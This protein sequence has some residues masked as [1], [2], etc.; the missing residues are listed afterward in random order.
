[1]RGESFRAIA[2]LLG[3][4]NLCFLPF[5]WGNKTLL[6][7]AQEGPSVMPTGA[8]AGVPS[9]LKFSTNLDTG[10]GGFFAEPNL[11]LLRYLYFHERSP[12]SGT[13]IKVMAVRSPRTS[14]RSPFIL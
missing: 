9:A 1:V 11:P 8:W 6:D 14:N 2:I 3:I 10:A 7:S 12:R 5:T 13:S 4:L